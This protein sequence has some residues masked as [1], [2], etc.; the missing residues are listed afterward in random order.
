MLYRFRD[1]AI[2]WSKIADV[3]LTYLY[4]APQLAVTLLEFRRDLW[5]IVW[6]C[7]R[8]PM[9]SRFGTIPACD[10]WIDTRRRH[11]PR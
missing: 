9:F 4:L 3:N 6:R 2:Y 5:A 11:T 1:I 7:L 8:D 10:R